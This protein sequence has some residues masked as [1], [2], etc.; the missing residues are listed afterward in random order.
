[1]AYACLSTRA[2]LYRP[3]LYTSIGV[4]AAAAIF[5]AVK[6]ALYDYSIEPSWMV[7]CQ[8]P[9]ALDPRRAPG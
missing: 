8:P 4:A 6:G 1:M 3:Y 5:I 2:N 7:S 9:R